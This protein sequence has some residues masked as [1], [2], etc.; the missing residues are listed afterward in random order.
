MKLGKVVSSLAVAIVG[1][2]PYRASRALRRVYRPQESGARGRARQGK[3]RVITGAS[4]GD[5]RVIALECA[6]RGAWV[7]LAARHREALEIAVAERR[8]VSGPPAAGNALVAMA[9]PEQVRHLADLTWAACRRIDVWINN[10]G[11]A[12]AGPTAE[13]PEAEMRWLLDLSVWGV[14]YDSR[15]AL[16][17]FQRQG[18]GRLVNMASITRRVAFPYTGF[19]SA[20]KALVEVYTQAL[21]QELLHVEKSGVRVSAVCPVAVRA[22]LP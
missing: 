7:V 5:G 8:E 20:S 2:A 17:V 12:F 6:R 18:R 11:G 10:A 19:Y 9:T 1:L 22:Q 13:S 16:Q 4:G 3:V 21:R 15:V 14:I